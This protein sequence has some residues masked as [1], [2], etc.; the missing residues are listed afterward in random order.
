MK[1]DMV[2]ACCLGKKPYPSKA[3]ALVDVKRINDRN[4]RRIHAYKCKACH[5]FH[6]GAAKHKVDRPKIM[7]RLRETALPPSG[8]MDFYTT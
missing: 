3:A 4:G 2:A 1:K 6:V 8:P 7:E 5:H